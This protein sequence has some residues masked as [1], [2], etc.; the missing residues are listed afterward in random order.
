MQ[1]MPTGEINKQVEQQKAFEQE[2]EKVRVHLIDKI[3]QD[4]NMYGIAQ[5]RINYLEIYEVIK[6]GLI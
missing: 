4:E 3:N 5:I 6:G 2:L 1:R